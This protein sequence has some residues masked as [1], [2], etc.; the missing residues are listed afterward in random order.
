MRKPGELV[1][2]PSTQT[3]IRI[4]SK[5]I[6]KI[7]ITD[8]RAKYCIAEMETGDTNDVAI[9]CVARPLLP[10]NQMPDVQ[11]PRSGSMFK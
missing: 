4:D 5:V 3:P 11:K 6:G 7:R 9:G 8:V 10:P 2:D 1:L